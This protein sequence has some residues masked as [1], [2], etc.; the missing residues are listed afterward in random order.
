M[1]TCLPL[2]LI[3]ENISV[4]VCC[5]RPIDARFLCLQSWPFE[6][7]RSRF[8]QTGR[9]YTIDDS[10]VKLYMINLGSLIFC[11]QIEWYPAA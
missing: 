8:H 10:L 11:A 2:A 4:K 3:D 1:S 9:K 6:V 7:R 5:Y